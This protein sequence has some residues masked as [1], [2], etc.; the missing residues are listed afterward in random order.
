MITH[1]GRVKKY[2]NVKKIMILS[3][4]FDQYHHLNDVSLACGAKIFNSTIDSSLDEYEY[5]SY[6]SL[7]K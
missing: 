7:F 3:K 6:E 4:M 1:N 2:N 5:V